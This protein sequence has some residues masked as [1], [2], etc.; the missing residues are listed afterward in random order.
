MWNKKP[1]T[2]AGNVPI[3]DRDEL[4]SCSLILSVKFTQ[5]YWGTI[6]LNN[7]TYKIE[8]CAIRL[9]VSNTWPGSPSI[10]VNNSVVNAL[11]KQA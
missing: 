11:P 9:L 6:F 1:H 3:T 10:D 2:N 5:R 7:T 8:C 4:C